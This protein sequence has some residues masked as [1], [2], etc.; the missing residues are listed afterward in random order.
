MVILDRD[1][2]DM[3]IHRLHD[4]GYET[5][6]PVV[7]DGAIVPGQ[8]SELSDLPV[9]YHDEQEPGHYRVHRGDDDEVFGW[10]VGPGSWKAAFFPPREVVWQASV[11]DEGPGGRE[12]DP[13]RTRPLAL[14]GVRPCEVAATAV[15][16]RVL[17]GSAAPDPRYEQRR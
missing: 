7:R 15:L 16:D 1:G 8:V 6:G 4:L 12:P 17:S 10:A 2:L 3:A 9:G 5:Q 14:I 11:R 13:D